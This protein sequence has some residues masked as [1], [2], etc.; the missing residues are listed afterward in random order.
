MK[1]VIILFFIITGL[2]GC[3]ENKEKEY[4]TNGKIKTELTVK[5]G[6]KNGLAKSYYE[7][8]EIKREGIYLNNLLEGKSIY[9]YKNGEI[10]SETDYHA[11]KITG[12]RKE[13]YE[14]GILEAI[15]NLK[16]G[17]QEGEVKEYY[18]TG[19]LKSV[20]NYTENVQNGDL[21]FYYPNGVIQMRALMELGATIYYQK[22]DSLGNKGKEYREV[23]CEVAFSNIKLGET[24]TAKLKLTGPIDSVAID[25]MSSEG[26][27]I[28]RIESLTK[29]LPLVGK[30]EGTYSFKPK[31][32]GKYTFQI[33]Y[34]VNDLSGYH[35]HDYWYEGNFNCN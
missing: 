35:P 23:R 11:G 8:G 29:V 34:L 12:L 15:G 9:Y 30:K 10:E 24:F 22:Y 31:K 4:Y 2:S 5:D 14:N 13:Y 21:Y 32:K 27:K 16:E 1:R 20:V 26:G 28:G 3:S 17:M 18:E 33:W 19:K 7:T 6:K 25:A